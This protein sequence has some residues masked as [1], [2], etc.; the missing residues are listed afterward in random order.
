MI[1]LNSLGRLS[2]PE[3]YDFSCMQCYQ[4]RTGHRTGKFTSSK[5][6]WSDSGPTMKLMILVTC[7]VIRIGLVIERVSLLVQSSNGRTRVRPFLI[8]YI[9]NINFN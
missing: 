8:K 7:K 9:S 2:P 3:T 5:F 6:K 1:C 4:N